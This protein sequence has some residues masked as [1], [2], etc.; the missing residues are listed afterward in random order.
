M[1]YWIERITNRVTMEKLILYCLFAIFIVAVVMSYFGELPFT[2]IAIITSFAVLIF[3]SYGINLL[4]GYL[5]NVGVSYESPVITAL[6]LGFLINPT[7]DV[8]GL[9]IIAFTAIVAMASKF[10]LAVRGRHLF[11]PAAIAVLLVG[12]T[13]LQ[14]ATWWVATPVLLPIV[15]LG[16][17]LILHKT[18]HL[19][20]GTLFV[21]IAA[22]T[23]IISGILSGSD[24][25]YIAAAAFL[26]W[27]II[28]FAG[29]MLT[30]PMTLPPRRWQKLILAALAGV[31]IALPF[32]IAGFVSSPEFVL[33]V[34]NFIAF[35]YGQRRGV[36][37]TLSTIRA[38]TP[39]VK[40]F[41]F[42]PVKGV[43]F[44][45]GQYLE[46][47]LPHA[48]PDQ[49]GTRR[50]FSI[51]GIP[52]GKEL[53]VS[54]KIPQS[55]SSF[56]R[57][58]DELKP[59]AFLT[60][61]RISGDFV[62]PKNTRTPLLFIAGGIGITPFISHI[63]TL[64]EKGGGYNINLIYAV[65]NTEELAYIDELLAAGVSISVVSSTIH[66]KNPAIQYSDQPYIT[67]GVLSALVPDLSTRK[68]YVSGPPLMV[69]SVQKNLQ[70]L[71]VKHINKDFFNGY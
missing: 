47:N 25:S 21:A 16:A 51:V 48:K 61:T 17:F 40:E 33:V 50:S 36:R 7:L 28:F 26:S 14:Y 67:K 27:P 69:E 62:L 44:E 70:D 34:I 12:F 11:N 64:A 13:G 3:V 22:T 30:E 6:I 43:R 8:V 4:L 15:L 32:H 1:N 53:A 18:R 54:V 55:P 10:V 9:V 60:A 42:R 71:G 66:A 49:K 68:V 19:L 29:Y 57:A 39:T 2:P 38:L 5:Y 41:T 59:G 45:A 37:L 56:K 31:G 23:I 35:F 52:N 46:L 20:M 65:N 58:L 63:R 24:F